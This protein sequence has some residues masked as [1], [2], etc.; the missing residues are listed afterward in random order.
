MGRGQS[1][2][3]A[4]RPDLPCPVEDQAGWGCWEAIQPSRQNEEPKHRTTADH[5]VGSWLPAGVLTE[6]GEQFP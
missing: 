1:S 4:V 2:L 6:G 3:G 5:A